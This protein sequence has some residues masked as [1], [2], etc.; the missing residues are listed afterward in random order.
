LHAS[1]RLQNVQRS[2]ACVCRQGTDEER[3][4]HCRSTVDVVEDG[5]VDVL[6]DGIVD[7]LEDGIVDVV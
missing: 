7:V 3:T 6:E 1:F 4:Q 5:S 2:L